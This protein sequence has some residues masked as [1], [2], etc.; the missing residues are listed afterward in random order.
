MKTITY[1]KSGG[2]NCTAS[3]LFRLIFGNSGVSL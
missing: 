1:M 2:P 3:S